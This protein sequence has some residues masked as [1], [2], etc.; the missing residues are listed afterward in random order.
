MQ[1]LEVVNTDKTAEM[2]KNTWFSPHY[3]IS[4]EHYL[5]SQK[6]KQLPSTFQI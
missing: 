3:N 4:S 1:A 6:M 2:G 5:V